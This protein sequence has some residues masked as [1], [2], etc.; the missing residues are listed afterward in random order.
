MIQRW[1]RQ[2]RQQRHDA[3]RRV[4]KISLPQLE[5]QS[6]IVLVFEIGEGSPSG[7]AKPNLQARE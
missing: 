6:G 2:A 7:L 5:S 3:G 4:A 1:D